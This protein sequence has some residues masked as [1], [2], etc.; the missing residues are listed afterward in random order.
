MHI[1]D[2]RINAI[3]DTGVDAKLSE[4]SLSES[5]PMARLGDLSVSSQTTLLGGGSFLAISMRRFP[6]F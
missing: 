3:D 2:L 1:L 4:R 6:S 5:E